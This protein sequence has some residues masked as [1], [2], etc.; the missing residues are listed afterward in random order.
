MSP[1]PILIKFAKSHGLAGMN[2]L[3]ER[4]KADGRTVIEQMAQQ[5]DILPESIAKCATRL[6][7]GRYQSDAVI[8]A[9]Q[10]YRSLDGHTSGHE[11]KRMQTIMQENHGF[12]G[13]MTA[14]ADAFT[15][16]LGHEWAD[17]FDNFKKQ[18]PTE[19]QSS[20]PSSDMLGKHKDVLSEPQHAY[21]GDKVSRVED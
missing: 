4:L 18:N 17:K 2:E 5:L 13:S 6:Y 1:E 7:G 16:L 11:R 3:N 15:D 14:T 20:M 8:E 12:Y 10:L 9:V 21:L 19:A